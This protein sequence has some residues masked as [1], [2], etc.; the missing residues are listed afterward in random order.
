MLFR[1]HF[2]KFF[3]KSQKKQGNEFSRHLTRAFQ[4]CFLHL[5]WGGNFDT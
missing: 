4:M 2:W 1:S 5:A 3:F